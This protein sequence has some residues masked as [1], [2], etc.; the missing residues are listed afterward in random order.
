MKKSS[1]LLTGAIVSLMWL[2]N[3]HD[4]SATPKNDCETKGPSLDLVSTVEPGCGQSNGNITVEA[5]GGEGAYSYILNGGQEQESGTFEGLS[6]RSFVV[7]VTDING[8]TAELNVDLQNKDGINITNVSVTGSG[9]GTSEGSISVSA[10]GSIEPYEFSLDGSPFSSED[11]FSGLSADSYEIVARDAEGCETSRS[12]I[13][14]TGVS[15]SDDISPI[16]SSNCAVSGCHNGAQSPTLTSTSAIISNASNIKSLT[17]TGA[18]PKEGSLSKAE[19]DMI[20]CW[21]NDG[22]MNN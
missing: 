14:T 11:S 2:S 13:V 6:S 8:C 16:I 9:C 22:A 4:E 12:A 18:M 15:L 21:V 7:T 5:S 19:I 3:C 20:A 10:S 17:A 1:I